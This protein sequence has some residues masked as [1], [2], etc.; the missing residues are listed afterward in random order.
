MV[1]QFG[2][3]PAHAG[4]TDAMSTAGPMLE[5]HPRSR[6]EYSQ[7]P[8]TSHDLRGSPPLTRGIQRAF[9]PCSCRHRFTPA[10]AGNT[11]L[12]CFIHIFNEVHPRSR[13]EYLKVTEYRCQRVGSPPLTRG[14]LFAIITGRHR[15]RFT[16]AHAGNTVYP[17]S[18]NC[19]W[20][21]HPR[22]RG[23]Y[24]K[25]SLILSHFFQ[26]PFSHFI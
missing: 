10:H 3:T 16:P 17:A 6:G 15:F 24:T 7:S 11:W 1:F 18:A 23:E 12:Y 5:V 9:Q 25:K 21:V 8:Y 22:S 14:I 26:H 19:S 20:K 2:F 13:G 4:N